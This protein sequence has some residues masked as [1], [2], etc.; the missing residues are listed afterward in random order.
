MKPNKH[1]C[2][3]CGKSLAGRQHSARICNDSSCISAHR[4][5]PKIRVCR[6]CGRE[7]GAR[8]SR[9]DCGSPDCVTTTQLQ[10]RKGD[11]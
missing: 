3:V 2:R 5:P 1:N 9:K 11:T 7:F 6:W 4:H 10:A 8:N